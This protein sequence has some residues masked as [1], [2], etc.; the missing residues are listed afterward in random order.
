MRPNIPIEE[1]WN[2]YLDAMRDT[3]IAND[4]AWSCDRQCRL[5]RLVRPDAF[6]CSV[7]TYSVCQRKDCLVGLF[8]TLGK[9]IRRTECSSKLSAS[10]VSAQGNDA[11]CT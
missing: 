4:R 9:D 5:H 11:F 6:K 2:R 10:R 3:N 7:D 8:T 1:R